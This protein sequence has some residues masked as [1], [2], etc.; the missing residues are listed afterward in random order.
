MVAQKRFLCGVPIAVKGNVLVKGVPVST[1]KTALLN[2]VKPIKH[3]PAVGP[4]TCCAASSFDLA[5]LLFP[6]QSLH[7]PIVHAFHKSVC[8]RV[9]HLRC[10]Y[11]RVTTLHLHCCN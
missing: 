9:G 6:V 10:A 2:N 7:N 5:S 8:F 4:H 3:A 1:H 11:T